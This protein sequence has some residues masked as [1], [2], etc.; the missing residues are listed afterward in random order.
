MN[1]DIFSGKYTADEV[2]RILEI[3]N[4]PDQQRKPEQAFY[5]KSA[6]ENGPSWAEKREFVH[7]LINDSNVS[8]ASKRWLR[9][10]D[11]WVGKY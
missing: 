2:T 1:G 6:M 10:Q 7:W 5:K 9:E 3:N 4:R 8:P 11:H